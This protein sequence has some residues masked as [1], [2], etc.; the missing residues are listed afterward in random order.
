MFTFNTDAPD[1]NK[2]QMVICKRHDKGPRII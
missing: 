2:V 1:N